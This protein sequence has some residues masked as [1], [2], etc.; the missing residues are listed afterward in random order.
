MSGNVHLR[1][2]PV[3]ILSGVAERVE[4]GLGGKAKADLQSET[5]RDG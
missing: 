4:L 1:T 3:E 5:G 2:D